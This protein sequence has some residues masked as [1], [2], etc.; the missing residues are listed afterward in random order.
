[1]RLSTALDLI[2]IPEGPYHEK[3]KV[4][5]ETTSCIQ[6]NIVGLPQASI[7]GYN[8]TIRWSLLKDLR[9]YSNYHV[10]LTKV[11]SFQFHFI[12]NF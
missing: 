4:T 8:Q 2:P 10:A 1:M 3:T 7:L 5:F 11:P 9:L 12:S 6:S